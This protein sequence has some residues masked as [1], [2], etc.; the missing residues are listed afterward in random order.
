MEYGVN[1]KEWSRNPVVIMLVECRPVSV[2]H[3]LL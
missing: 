3:I 1:V 2:F